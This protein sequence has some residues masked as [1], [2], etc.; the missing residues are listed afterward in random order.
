MHPFTFQHCY[1]PDLQVKPSHC[2]APMAIEDQPIIQIRLM[3]LKDQ[4]DIVNAEGTERLVA[5][6]PL[7]FAATT[8]TGT[9]SGSVFDSAQL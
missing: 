7:C 5:G 4:S 1:S 3:A 6:K 9:A 2:V 8:R